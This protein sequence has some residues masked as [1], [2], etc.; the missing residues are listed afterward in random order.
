MLFSR[1]RH[2]SN[3]DLSAYLDGQLE[4]DARG[5][6]QSH[7]DACAPCR[8]A[9]EE[10]RAV[11]SALREL[12]RAAVP[13]SF[14]LREAD[15]RQ[16]P[17]AHPGGIFVRAMPMLSGVTAVAL[18]AFLALVGVDLSGG[19]SGGG[20]DEAGEAA[21]VLDTE[22]DAG[23]PRGSPEDESAVP[24]RSAQPAEGE[25]GPTEEP[26]AAPL[27]P[28]GTEQPPEG[29]ANF[30][31]RG[32]PQETAPLSAPPTDTSAEVEQGDGVPAGPTG[33]APEASP[34]SLEERAG[35]EPVGTMTV[36]ADELALLPA[37]TPV[38]A[39]RTRAQAEE[40]GRTGLRTAEAATAALA[41]VA[42]GSL[43]FAWWRRRA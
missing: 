2:A 35:G 39:D 8:A 27:S 38:P 43:A 10:L 37:L 23:V 6:V 33:H 40:D 41:L 31:D 4:A 17:A 1:P 18:F 9:L 11:R 30:A 19:T 7:V 42:G 32:A 12:P 22:F 34:P 14:A 13:R 21:G 3:D 5:R 16:A 15:V 26:G 24:Q 25:A 28:E 20:A 36:V 29:E